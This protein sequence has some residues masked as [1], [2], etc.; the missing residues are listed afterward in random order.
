MEK[1]AS[2]TDLFSLINSILE[3]MP[4]NKDGNLA[5]DHEII[6]IISHFIFFIQ[7]KKEEHNT[8]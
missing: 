4:V 7:N 3:Q 1:S 6:S 5:F 8:W 2:T